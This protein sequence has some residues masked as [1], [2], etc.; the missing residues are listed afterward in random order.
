LVGGPTAAT[1]DFSAAIAERF[2][3][4][5][6]VVIGLSA[7]LML[8]MLRS[9]AIAAKAAVLN[10]VSIGAS[11]GVVVLVFQDGRL[12]AQSGPIEAFVPVMMFA[13]VFGLSMDYEVFLVT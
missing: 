10:V 12:M 5:V 9:V 1:V 8:F 3:W 11:L 2:P 6:G 7:V 4:F 13:I